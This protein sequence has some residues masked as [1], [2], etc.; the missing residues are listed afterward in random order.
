MIA[1]LAIAEAAMIC[2][3]FI[4]TSGMRWLV[5]WRCSRLV[6]TTCIFYYWEWN[7]E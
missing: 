3:T 1:D 6:G 2:H 4:G 7:E 5:R